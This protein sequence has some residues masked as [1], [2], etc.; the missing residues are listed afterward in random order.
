MVAYACMHV[1]LATV[2]H[3]HAVTSSTSTP[4]GVPTAQ[5]L[6]LEVF[7]HKQDFLNSETS[8]KSGIKCGM[9]TNACIRV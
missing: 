5:N 8:L 7:N 4:I 2:V 3:V 6:Y 1:L 9:L